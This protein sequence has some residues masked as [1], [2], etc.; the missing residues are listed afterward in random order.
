M[1]RR[2]GG[3]MWYLLNE[4]GDIIE[5]FEDED[6]ATI[7]LVLLNNPTYCIVDEDNYDD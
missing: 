2:I 5:V 7:A 4:D 6:A 3:I 1:P